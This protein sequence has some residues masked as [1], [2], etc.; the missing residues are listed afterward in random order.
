M[1][2]PILVKGV[3]VLPTSQHIWTDNGRTET[4]S[5]EKCVL[6][7]AKMPLKWWKKQKE[8]PSSNDNNVDY[9]IDV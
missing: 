6:A 4:G 3:F 5:S 7:N 2:L 9:F 1:A 8:N